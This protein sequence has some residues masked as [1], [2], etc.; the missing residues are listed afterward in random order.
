MSTPGT[1]QSL[2]STSA[3]CARAVTATSAPLAAQSFSSRRFRADPCHCQSSHCYTCCTMCLWQ[4]SGANLCGYVLVIAKSSAPSLSP[5][6]ACCEIVLKGVAHRDHGDGCNSHTL[7]VAQP[8]RDRAVHTEV[9][10]VKRVRARTRTHAGDNI[11]TRRHHS[12]PLACV[13]QA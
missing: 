13:T 12:T 4:V 6:H 3:E 2:E 8:C 7:A 1:H 10:K 11:T 5:P 9:A